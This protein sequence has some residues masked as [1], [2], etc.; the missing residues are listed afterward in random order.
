MLRKS[1]ESPPETCRRFQ[2]LPRSL[3]KRTTPLEPL[4]HTAICSAPSAPT[5]PAA[6]M[7]RR[8]VSMPVLCTD[9]E[10]SS[11]ALAGRVMVLG[12]LVGG[13]LPGTPTVALHKIAKAYDVRI[14]VRIARNSSIS[15]DRSSLIM[16]LRLL[17][18]H[19]L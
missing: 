8:L 12:S 19:L 5:E 7:P 15:G 3:E 4:A 1:S 6:L 17:R 10:T 18:L 14:N 2:L 9:Q 11:G 13:R 16:R